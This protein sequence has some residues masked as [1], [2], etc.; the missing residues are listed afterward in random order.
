MAQKTKKGTEQVAKQEG[1]IVPAFDPYAIVKYPLSTEKS[2]HQIEFENKL[3]FVVSSRAG[4]SDVKK[5]VEELF[6]VKVLKVNIQN[7]F[8][9]VKKAYVKLAA[10][11]VASDV[12]ADLGMI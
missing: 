12:G 5:A 4:K 8:Q 6:K 11:S 7:S 10:S 9:G 3:V 1:S 2:I